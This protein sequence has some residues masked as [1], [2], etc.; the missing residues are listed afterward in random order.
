MDVNHLKD[1]RFQGAKCSS[2][3]TSEARSHIDRWVWRMGMTSRD[4]GSVIVSTLTWNA[5][6]AGSNPALGAV[7]P[8]SITLH[9][10]LQREIGVEDLFNILF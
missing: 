3:L 5:R 1:I 6:G 7:F 10:I 4:V 2:P 9:N 8:I